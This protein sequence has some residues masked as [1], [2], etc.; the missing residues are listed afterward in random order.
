MEVFLDPKELELLQ[1]V[2]DN[3]LE[4]LRREIH[5]TDSRIF[6]AQL[7]ADEARMEG[8]LAK[9]RVQAAMGI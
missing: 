4:D 9:L 8:I 1:R 6:K 2:L 7:R 3:R 5:H